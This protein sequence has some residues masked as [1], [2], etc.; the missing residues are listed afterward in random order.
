MTLHTFTREKLTHPDLQHQQWLLTLN[1]R[2]FTSSVPENI[3]RIL[4]VGT[5]AGSWATGVAQ[6]YPQVEVIGLDVTPP[7]TT[8]STEKNLTFLEADAEKP[9]PFPESHFD[10][11]HGRMLV[12]ALH[13][14]PTFLER[15]YMHLM[16]GGQLDLPE[17]CYPWDSALTG[18]GVSPINSSFLR[19]A[20]MAGQA[21]AGAGFDNFHVLRHEY[22]MKQIGFVD[23]EHFESRWPVG[24][25][26]ENERE[27]KIGTLC[28]GIYGMFMKTIGVKILMMNGFMEI[29]EAELLTAAA[30]KDVEENHMVKKYFIPV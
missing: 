17:T 9:W 1:G 29:E 13:D 15:C 24:P 30:V 2:L 25:W 3:Q 10:F 14:W 23:V 11:I 6:A 8:S 18:E 20:S 22:R 19:W 27:Q 16:P 5:G 12:G 26:S 21:W 4:D 7:P 28:L